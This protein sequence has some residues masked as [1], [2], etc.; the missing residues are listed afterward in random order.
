VRIDLPPVKVLDNI[1][2]VGAV[3]TIE[4]ALKSAGMELVAPAMT[5]KWVPDKD[6]LQKCYEYGK[7]FAKKI[8]ATE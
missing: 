6:E 7:E 5:V 1:Y 8:K 4:K 2:W 3:G